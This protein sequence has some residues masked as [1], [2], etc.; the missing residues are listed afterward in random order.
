[1]CFH[2]RGYGFHL[3]PHGVSW[4]GQKKLISKFHRSLK[5]IDA[6]KDWIRN[7]ENK[8]KK[9]NLLKLR[10]M[11]SKERGK[12]VGKRSKQFTFEGKRIWREAVTFL[13]RE[14]WL[15]LQ[16]EKGPSQY[17]LW[18]FCPV[19]IKGIFLK[20]SERKHKIAWLKSHWIRKL[21]TATVHVEGWSTKF[22]VLREMIW[23]HKYT[24][25]RLSLKIPADTD[26]ASARSSC[27]YFF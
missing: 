12:V 26:K 14:K 24:P 20:F 1:M 6:A 3:R 23:T 25:A 16:I 8:L 22:Q 17:I 2:C 5:K 7:L 11:M 18:H 27:L 19:R 10:D 4:C 15:G 21:Q 13:K 9:R